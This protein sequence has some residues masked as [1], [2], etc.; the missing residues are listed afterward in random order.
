MIEAIWL[1]LIVK[2]TFLVIYYRGTIRWSMM[3]KR[4][5]ICFLILFLLS[6]SGTA[7]ET[8]Y[9]LVTEIWPPFRIEDESNPRG[10][11]GIDIDLILEI[12]KRLN[13]QIEI[14][15]C[16]WARALY[17]IEHG[18]ADLI[19]GL[20]YTE[21]RARFATY[22]DVPYAAVE[23]VF[24]TTYGRSGEFQNYEDFAGKSIGQSR[25]SAYFDK[26]NSDNSLNKIPYDSE[27][28]ILDLLVLDRI[29]LGIGTNPNMAYDIA[30]Y[31]YREK[32]EPTNYSPPDSTDLYLAFSQESQKIQV[33]DIF[34]KIM[35]EIVL[36][37]T[38][39]NILKK[40]R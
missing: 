22:I 40:Y 25:D 1:R 36:D 20:A 12:E 10:L 39:E 21:E 16:P 33:F 38:M 15:E 7:Q 28:Q 27:K 2:T 30:R 29:D 5:T 8:T 11:S 3:L 6:F 26:Y 34:S 4:D 23:P 9:L 17:M 37:G 18:L 19:I 35:K 32:L 24:Y 14:L 13:I 31:G